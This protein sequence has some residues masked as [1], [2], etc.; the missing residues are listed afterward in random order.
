MVVKNSL[1]ISKCTKKLKQV[2]Y[3]LFNTHTLELKGGSKNS[4]KL[5]FLLLMWIGFDTDTGAIDKATNKWLKEICEFVCKAQVPG[6]DL[7]SSSDVA[8]LHQYL[9]KQLSIGIYKMALQY[10]KR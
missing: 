6:N 5:P 3:N 2:V 1:L 4:I 10:I 9:L 7:P 8:M